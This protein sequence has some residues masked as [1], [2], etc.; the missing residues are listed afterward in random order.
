MPSSIHDIQL[1]SAYRYLPNNDESIGKVKRGSQARLKVE[2][3]ARDI[4]KVKYL[5]PWH[6]GSTE[7]GL[8]Q[9]Q[10]KKAGI[11]HYPS[12]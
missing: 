1:L 4:Q 2:S 7:Q 8:Q 9:S 3:Q 5:E 11:H 6:I 12:C 10:S